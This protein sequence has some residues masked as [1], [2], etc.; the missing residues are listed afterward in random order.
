MNWSSIFVPFSR[1]S[2]GLFD[3]YNLVDLHG[4]VTLTTSGNRAHRGH[5]YTGEVNGPL[6]V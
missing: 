5:G 6:N 4:L 2:L 1:L 3:S